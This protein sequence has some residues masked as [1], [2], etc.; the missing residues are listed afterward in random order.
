MWNLQ[1]SF[2]GKMFNEYKSF[3]VKIQVF[4]CENTLTFKQISRHEVV[5]NSGWIKQYK[6]KIRLTIIKEE[7]NWRYN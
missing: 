1:K 6:L 7:T 2:S 5:E 4:L 3:Y